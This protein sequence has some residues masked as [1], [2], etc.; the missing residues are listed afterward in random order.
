V[1]DDWFADLS[2]VRAPSL[3]LWGA[4][5]PYAPVRFGER[6]AKNVG[7]TFTPVDSGHWYELEQPDFVAAQLQA[8]WAGLR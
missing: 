5:D 4:R 6:L 1:A 7:G 3:I 2:K 8:F